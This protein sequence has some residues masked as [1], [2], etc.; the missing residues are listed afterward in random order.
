M[1][2]LGGRGRVGLRFC[3]VIFF[4]RFFGKGACGVLVFEGF[5]VFRFGGL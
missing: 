4:S 5:G 1:F 3:P 2:G